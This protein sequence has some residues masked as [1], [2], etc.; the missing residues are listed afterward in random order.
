LEAKHLYWEAVDAQ[1]ANPT[2]VLAFVNERRAAGNQ[3]PVSLSGKPLTMEL[4]QQKGIDTYLGGI[5][6]GDLRRWLRGGDD[7]FPSGTHPTEEWGQYGDATCF[8][9][10]SNEYDGNPN[11]NR[12]R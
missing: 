7:M 3:D 6:N 5:R 9:L 12:P 2:G 10:P 4:R 11:I 1:G 8:P